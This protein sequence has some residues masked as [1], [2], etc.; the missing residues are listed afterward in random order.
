MWP[1]PG[2]LGSVVNVAVATGPIDWKEHA[3]EFSLRTAFEGVSCRLEVQRQVDE[4]SAVQCRKNALAETN[5]SSKSVTCKETVAR[6]QSSKGCSGDTCWCPQCPGYVVGKAL[7]QRHVVA[8]C[9][10]MREQNADVMFL[11]DLSTPE[12][13]TEGNKVVML[14]LEEYTLF[15]SG[16]VG[17]VLSRCFVKLWQ[18]SG[19]VMRHS[20]E[21]EVDWSHSSHWCFS[22]SSPLSLHANAERRECARTET[23]ALGTWNRAAVEVETRRRPRD[24]GR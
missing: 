12:W 17:I 3:D 8:H 19:S 18:N 10:K 7:I 6:L 14:G 11:S 16:M 4:I 23:R 13:M 5:F 22:V 1:Q 20:R 9:E 2:A 24:P 15:V 21:Q